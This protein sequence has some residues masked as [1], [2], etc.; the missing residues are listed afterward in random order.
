MLIQS[1]L[2]I[3]GIIAIIVGGAMLFIPVA[4]EASAGIHLGENISLLSEVRAPGGTL[5]VAGILIMSG[6]FVAKMT[7]I[8]ILLSCLFYLSYGLSR[9]LGIMM[10]GV[11]SESL[12]IATVVEIIIGL[13]SLFLMIKLRTKQYKIRLHIKGD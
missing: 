11:P 10:D 13:V 1:L 8:S 3:A 4:F 5:L 2:I 12:M 6:A 7:H 9:V